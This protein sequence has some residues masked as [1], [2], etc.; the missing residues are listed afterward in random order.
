MTNL[1]I[2]VVIAA[3]NQEYDKKGKNFLMTDEQKMLMNA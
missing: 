1:F 2:A 3:F